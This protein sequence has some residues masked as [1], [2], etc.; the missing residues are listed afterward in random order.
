MR[1]PGH[2]LGASGTILENTIEG[3]R[4][5]LRVSS[6][7]RFRYWEFDIRESSDGVLF[8]YHDDTIESG[9]TK[10]ETAKMRF[11]KIVEAG[12]EIGIRIPTFWEVVK[13]LEDRDEPVM[14]EIK[15]IS[16]DGARK[17]VIDA[18][19]SKPRWKVM[20]TPERFEEIFPL[21]TRKQWKEMFDSAGVEVVRV[22]RHRVDLFKASESGIGWFLAQP[23]WFFGI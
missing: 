20:A 12:L 17:E 23:K 3:F 13:E 1:N 11:G 14:V 10:I 8:V 9:G 15:Q 4:E 5:S 22:G 2:R 7:S 19:S 16:T 21:E 6:E 18:L